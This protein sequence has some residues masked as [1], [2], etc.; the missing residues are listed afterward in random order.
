[1]KPKQIT[2]IRSTISQIETDMSQIRSKD[3]ISSDCNSR[4]VPQA[5]NFLQEDMLS[6]NSEV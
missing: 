5:A 2:V 3:N 1:M 6:T 4:D